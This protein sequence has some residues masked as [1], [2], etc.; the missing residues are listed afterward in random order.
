[1]SDQVIISIVGAVVSIVTVIVAN[2]RTN[3][4][5]DN[6][7]KEVN[8]KLSQLIVA[9]KKVSKQEGKQEEKNDQKKRGK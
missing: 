1:M 7:H 4:K 9:E 3:R 2:W 8:S 6:Y 5:V